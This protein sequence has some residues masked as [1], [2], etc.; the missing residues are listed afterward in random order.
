M[1][2]ETQLADADSTWARLVA[3]LAEWVVKEIASTAR[4]RRSSPATRLTQNN[5]RAVFGGISLPKLK[6]SVREQN[7]CSDCGNDI[8]NR[9]KKC[10]VC[11]VESSAQ[12]LTIAASGGRVASHRHKAEARR[13]KTQLINHANRREWSPSDQPTWLTA[14]FYAEKIQ[15]LLVPL[16]SGAISRYLAVSRGY[17]TEIR[18]GRVPHPRHW[19]PLA[20][21]I[22]L[23]E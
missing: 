3:P 9:H 17:A 22:G 21:L 4:T 20:R 15:P 5:K 23:S 13:S 12:R 10:S 8:H 11:A 16:S 6:S 2:T 7:M 18:H 1:M 19:K 14:K